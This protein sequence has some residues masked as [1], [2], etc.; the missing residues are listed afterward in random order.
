MKRVL[1][2]HKPYT[3]LP[4]IFDSPHSG[5]YYPADFGYACDFS[6]LKT[7]EDHFVDDLFSTAPEHGAT[8]LCAE[9]P[10]SYIDPNRAVD[11]IDPEL[12]EH[13]TWTGPTPIAPTPRSHAGIGLIRRLVRPGLP[14]YDRP[15]STEDISDRITKYYTPYHTA[16]AEEIADLH[17][18][19]GAVWHINCHA[20][21]HATA[22]PKNHIGL[23]GH[24]PK[25]A[26]FTLG[27]RD[28]TS[29]SHE[30]T[31]VLRHFL[32]QKGYTVT[33]NDPFK[34]AELIQ[35]YAN[36]ALGYHALQIEINKALYMDE[37]TGARSARY[38]ALK[39]DIVDLMVFCAAFVRAR[40]I[41]L[42]AD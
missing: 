22:Y 41:P 21:P 9:F 33:V 38:P 24:K 31:Q 42:A 7:A 19:F 14:V 36:P 28:G 26:D 1:S 8:L 5:T 35:R 13:K 34:G 16:L 23:A 30:F 4:L 18:T 11:D 32:Q 29:C 10:R 40:L 15:L 3:S 39:A 27:D 37:E 12:L 17:Y 2:L 6:I 25:A 20:M